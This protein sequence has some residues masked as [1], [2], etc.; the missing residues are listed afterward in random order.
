MNYKIGDEVT[1]VKDMYN[2]GEY[3]IYTIPQCEIIDIVESH[4]V[5]LY[6]LK[7]K[8]DKKYYSMLRCKPINKETLEN[9]MLDRVEFEIFKEEQE[10]VNAA[11]EYITKYT[12]HI[13]DK[14]LSHAESIIYGDDI[15]N[16]RTEL[17]AKFKNV[18]PEEGI[19]VDPD[20]VDM[21]GEIFKN[22]TKYKIN[23]K[24][25]LLVLY[26]NEEPKTSLNLKNMS[27]KLMQLFIDIIKFKT[28]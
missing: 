3:D 17:I 10:A 26:K 1:L 23:L 8:Q 13:Q 2:N 18:M 28:W 22:D 20:L 16:M 14:A 11:M 4:G 25:N 24:N 9:I 27:L 21:F 12:R 6:S 19:E 15:D 7:P 5:K